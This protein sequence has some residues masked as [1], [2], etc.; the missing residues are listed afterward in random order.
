[1]VEGNPVYIHPSSA[2]FNKNPEWMI[3]HELVLTSKEYMRQ[4]RR[5]S[6]IERTASLIIR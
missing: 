1:M 5:G 6:R 2:L 4:V 3:Y